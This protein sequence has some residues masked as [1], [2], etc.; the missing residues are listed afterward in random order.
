MEERKEVLAHAKK[1]CNRDRVVSKNSVSLYASHLLFTF[2][3]APAWG[4]NGNNPKSSE[5]S[6]LSDLE[7]PNLWLIGLQ[8]LLWLSI[9][10]VLIFISVWLMKKLMRPGN[11]FNSQKPINLLCQETIGPNRSVC[12][13]RVLDRIHVIGVTNT[14]I[15]HLSTLEDHEI[16][17]V[18]RWLEN[19]V[20]L[21]H[22]LKNGFQLLFQGVG[23]AQANQKSDLARKTER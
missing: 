22:R 14:Q 16:D 3:A 7:L 13:V 17:A 10:V 19:G 1:S 6:Q 8:M 23:R 20:L 11:Q 21:E 12:F 5:K 15:S 2:L 18:D 4:Q 9:V